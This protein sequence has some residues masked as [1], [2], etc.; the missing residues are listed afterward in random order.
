[1]TKKEKF[2]TFVTNRPELVDYIKNK[3]HTWQDFYEIYDI[4]GEDES[5]WKKYSEGNIDRADP[6][7]EL[8]S[9]VKGINIDN[10]QKY[11][12]NAQKAINVIQE[13]TTKKPGSKV[14]TM[15]PKTP[16]P[17]TKFFGD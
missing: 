16:R 11:I 1:M 5:V 6:I 7:I 10:V 9:L 3:E 17:L 12:N 13:L 4:Y 8:T 14:P 2:K 15:P